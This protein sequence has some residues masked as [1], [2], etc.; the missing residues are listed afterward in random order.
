MKNQKPNVTLHL[1]TFANIIPKVKPATIVA[2]LWNNE[3]IVYVSNP[4]TENLDPNIHVTV[5]LI[6]VAN[7]EISIEVLPKKYELELPPS[8]SIKVLY[9]AV[10]DGDT[11]R[12]PL[13]VAQF[14]AFSTVVNSPSISAHEKYGAVILRFKPLKDT[15]ETWKHT[16]DVPV[17]TTLDVSKY[18]LT[19]EPLVFTKVEDLWWG[20]AF[21]G[22]EFYNLS[23][24]SFRFQ[25][26]QLQIAHLQLWTAGKGV[27][28]GVH[29]HSD[30]VFQELHICLSPGTANG[31]MAKLKD[32]CV[33]K[34]SDSEHLN[35]LGVEAFDTLTLGQMEEHGGMWER[36]P[37]GLA[38]RDEASRVVKYPY[39]KWQAG[40]SD[41]VD[42]WAALEFGFDLDYRVSGIAQAEGSKKRV[43]PVEG[44]GMKQ[45]K[46]YTHIRRN[47]HP[48]GCC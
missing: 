20:S 10:K 4:A 8:T 9:G 15:H 36:D 5:P 32:N 31:G 47:A 7:Y 12:A 46:A 17:R 14:T 21:K 45:N 34:D 43:L 40:D 41:G 30:A 6:E 16:K 33:P 24:F 18:G 48:R 35:S 19:L 28:C 3:G 42:V 26:S 37:Y 27:N 25:D 39:H 2:S 22:K 44:L 29:N 13:S 1:N 11:W 23:G 38:V